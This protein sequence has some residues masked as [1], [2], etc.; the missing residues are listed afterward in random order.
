M[1]LSASA[2]LG[3]WWAIAIVSLGALA[4]SQALFLAVRRLDGGRSAAKLGPKF[5]RFETC[6]ARYGLWSVVGLRI[7]GAPHFLVTGG[8]ALLRV[9]AAGFALATLAGLLPVVALAAGA[10]SLL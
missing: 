2:L 8:S 9:P 7:C 10:G 4:G 6:F 5:Q 3:G 1:S